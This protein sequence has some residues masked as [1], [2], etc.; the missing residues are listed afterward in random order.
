VDA[1]SGKFAEVKRDEVGRAE[2]DKGK[3]TGLMHVES[4]AGVI[5]EYCM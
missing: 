4:I 5:C 2:K 3:T 1:I